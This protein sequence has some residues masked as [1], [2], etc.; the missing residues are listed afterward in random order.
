MS[1][2]LKSRAYFFV[3]RFVSFCF[4]LDVILIFYLAE[5][6]MKKLMI[7]LSVF[8]LPAITAKAA[9]DN[10]LQHQL[11]AVKEDIQVLQRQIARGGVGPDV[12]ELGQID[13]SLRQTVGRLDMIEHQIKTLEEKINMINKD[14]DVRLKMIEG[15][16]IEGGGMSAP[17]PAQ[18]FDAPVAENAPASIVGGAITKGNDLPEVKTKTA[19]QIYQEGLDAFNASNYDE[20]AVKFTSVQTKY[21]EHKLAGNAQ[22]WLG[23]SYYGKKDYAK[24]AVAFAKGYEKYKEGNKGADNLLKLGMSMQMLGKTEE[25]CTAFTSLPKEFPKAADNLKA[26][27]K[28]AV[29]ELKCKK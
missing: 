23:E 16:P 17:M 3:L 24:A 18:K 8:L 7:C 28:S 2:D 11:D 25:A 4:N 9:S 1:S 27:A 13:E 14:V 29:E 6:I 26:R 22:Y 20:A 5:M 21:P 12:V 10:A 19:E 15:K